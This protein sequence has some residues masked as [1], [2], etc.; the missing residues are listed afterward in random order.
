MIGAEAER[1][2]DIE[3][4]WSVQK[5]TNVVSAIAD[6]LVEEPGALICM[7]SVGRSHAAPV[8]GSV[9]EGVLD[10]AFGPLLLVGPNVREDRFTTTGPMLVCTDGSDT[11]KAILPVAGQWAIAMPF[12]P[13]VIN[14]LEPDI[15]ID[16]QLRDDIGP[17]VVHARHVAQEL[18]REIDRDVQY[19]VLHSDHPARAIADFAADHA[20][21]L[22]AMAT[23]GAG[24]VRRVVLG[25]VTM[26]V[27]HHAPCPVLVDRPPH[28]PVG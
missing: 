25:S 2:T 20:A 19:E 8:L 22:I 28:L 3:V 23:H 24:G 27:V 17:D 6:E 16:T 13:W 21:S 12:E 5:V 7:A 1:I 14:V 11:A 10:E 26:S 9:A 4:D 18:Q 15:E